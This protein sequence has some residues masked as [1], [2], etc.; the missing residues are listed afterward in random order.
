M[1]DYKDLYFQLFAAMS[2]ALEAIEQM[3]FGQAK[4]GLLAAVLK[5]EE[6]HMQD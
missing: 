2:D 1:P 5:A 4:Q 3:N 6:E